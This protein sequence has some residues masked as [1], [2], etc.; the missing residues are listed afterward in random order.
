M[1]RRLG[2]DLLRSRA[3]LAGL[4]LLLAVAGFVV[5]VP[6][7]WGP[8][9]DTID[10]AV[11]KQPPSGAHPLGTDFF[12]RDLLARVAAGG[13]ESLGIS[14]AALAIV[15]AFGFLYGAAAALLPP[16]LDAVLMRLVDALLAVPRLPV[17]V[18]VLV[19]F[20]LNT[21]AFTVVV[22]LSVGG[23][24]IP[25]RLV[26]LELVA[27]R[28]RPFVVAARSVGVGPLRLVRL[29]LLPNTLGVLL[30]A[31]FL[32]LPTLVLSEAFASALGLGVNPPTPTWGNIAYDGLDEAR[33]WQVFLP[34][35]AI[36]VFTIAANLVA[37]GIQES[38]TP[39]GTTWR[40]RSGPGTGVERAVRA[41]FGR[42]RRPAEA[43]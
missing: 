16:R 39:G 8:D 23:W 27:L 2:G 22:A 4:A 26:R 34:S 42:P 30:V 3:G 18:I 7:L 5:L 31:A 25:A 38:L 41:L 37:D 10:F 33:A 17:I 24:M 6:W 1:I 28:Q 32:E 20:G 9:A 15:L 13:R 36:A 19:L 21:S 29:H 11:A 12:G 14:C 43:G 40:G 35:V